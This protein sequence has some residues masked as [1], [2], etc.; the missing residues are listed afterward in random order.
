MRRD[1][2]DICTTL[3]HEIQAHHVAA[4]SEREREMIQLRREIHDIASHV[5]K[6]QLRATLMVSKRGTSV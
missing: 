6:L 3:I 4:L 2:Y 1:A 5:T